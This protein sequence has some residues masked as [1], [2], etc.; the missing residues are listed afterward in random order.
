MM[1]IALINSSLSMVCGPCFN[2]KDFLESLVKRFGHL[3]CMRLTETTWLQRECWTAYGTNPRS[4]IQRRYRRVQGR[5]AHL[6][7]AYILKN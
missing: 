7:T 3:Y 5:H 1:F 6:H 2:L 4:Q